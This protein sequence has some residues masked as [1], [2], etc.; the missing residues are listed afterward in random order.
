MET[1]KNKILVLAL[2][3]DIMGDDGAALEA[4]DLLEKEFAGEIDIFK[5]SSAGFMLLD[6]LEG[7]EKVLILDT[8]LAATEPGNFRELTLSELSGRLSESPHY[9]GLPEVINLAEKLGIKFPDEI[10]IFVIEI[11][12]PF[13][14]RQ[15]LSFK[16]R[17]NL[18]LFAQKVSAQINEWLHEYET[19]TAV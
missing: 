15:G 3:N 7:Y 4:A 11:E 19:H 1:R 6:I 17:Y 10:K 2:G 16:I 9:A 14:I 8:I 18:H 5:V 12:D 13:I